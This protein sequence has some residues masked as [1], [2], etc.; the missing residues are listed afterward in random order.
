MDFSDLNTFA[1]VA[2]CSSI[3]RAARELHTVQ[4]N[5]TTRVKMLED[6]VGVPLF[7]R[8]N[9][10]VV[11][12]SAGHRLLPYATRAAGL[13]REAATAARDDGAAHGPLTIGS[14]ETTLAVRLPSVL[15]QFHAQY[16]SVQMTIRPGPT[17]MLVDSVLSNDI[18]GAFVAGPI[19]HAALTAEAVFEEELVLITSHRWTDLKELH[20]SGAGITALMFRTGCTYRQRL[21][22]A[23]LDAGWPSFQR[24]E[25][26]TL[27]GILG[28]IASDFGVSLLPRSVVEHSGVRHRVRMH[29]V[30]P[31]IGRASTLFIRRRHDH[32]SSALRQ[33]AAHLCRGPLQMNAAPVANHTLR[34]PELLHC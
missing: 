1:A 14:M 8:N 26:G 4:S 33:F 31:L 7:E 5:V 28:C 2:R 32:Q 24:I 10:G 25:F 27:D 23:L 16:P 3:T 20:D 13:L 9:R 11:L 12:T 18:D 6:E 34:E 29:T 22:Q 30:D 21:E 19:N 15:A 17:S